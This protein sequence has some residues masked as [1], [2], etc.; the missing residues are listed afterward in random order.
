MF[1]RATLRISQSPF[2][3]CSFTGTLKFN[4]FIKNLFFVV[5][6]SDICNFIDD[7]TLFSSGAKWKAVLQ[8]LEHH[9]N[10]LLYWFKMNSVKVDPKSFNS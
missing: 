2:N 8:N 7:N 10:K 9:A 6:K 4:I 1:D 3:I 5:E